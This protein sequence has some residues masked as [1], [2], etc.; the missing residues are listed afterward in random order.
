[1]KNCWFAVA[2]LGASMLFVVQS[3]GPVSAQDRESD[4]RSQSRIARYNPGVS[5]ALLD[6]LPSSILDSE[7]KIDPNLKPGTGFIVLDDAGAMRPAVGQTLAQR[8]M[9]ERT[10]RAQGAGCRTSADVPILVR[11]KVVDSSCAAVIGTTDRVRIH[12]DVKTNPGSN[13]SVGW[14]GMGYQKKTVNVNPVP[15]KPKYVTKYVP[16]WTANKLNG[17]VAP[18][19]K[20]AAVPKM[21]FS[22]GSL[23]GWAGTF[24][25]N[26]G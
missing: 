9:A 24:S 25:A 22:N 10:I 11:D 26:G 2:S 14:G 18:W 3:A 5:R 4:A 1:M 15:L 6:S 13:G 12:Y 23:A 7:I 16:V 17:G 8:R 20:I 21:R 19:G